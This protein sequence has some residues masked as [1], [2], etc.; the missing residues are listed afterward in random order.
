MTMHLCSPQSYINVTDAY[1]IFLPLPLFVDDCKAGPLPQFGD[2]AGSTNEKIHSAVSADWTD[3]DLHFCKVTFHNLMPT[4]GYVRSALAEE[5][6]L[7][8]GVSRTALN[9]IWYGGRNGVNHEK[10]R[11]NLGY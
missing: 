6:F 11:E 7:P 5:M 10:G 8:A 4:N 2:D 1:F 3:K 9:P